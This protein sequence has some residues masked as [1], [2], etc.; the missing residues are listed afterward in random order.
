[1]AEMGVA[2]AP[3]AAL[4]P[5]LL[6]Q[7]PTL[8]EMRS[9][10]VE[11][12]AQTPQYTEFGLSQ[13]REILS[14]NP[15]AWGD[16]QLDMLHK[17]APRKLLIGRATSSERFGL[18]DRTLGLSGYYPL[19]AR[20]TAYAEL[21]SSDTHRVLAR[22][23]LH[24]Q[25]AQALSDGWGVLGG[26]RHVNYN[27]TAVDVADLTLERYFSDYRIALSAYPSRSQIAGG[28]NSYR[29]QFSRYYGAE[30]NLQFL[31]A[32]GTEV[33]KPT[34]VDSVLAASVRAVAL[35]GR[36]WL[37]RDV[38]LVYSIGRTVQGESTR[39]AASLGLRYRF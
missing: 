12:P 11:L 29:L 30:N 2:P 1:M 20:T 32:R 24:L 4:E 14:N 7:G 10:A 31:I 34:G 9:G 23:S 17:F 19:A 8:P 38:S 27:S 25:L 6:A 5:L 22:D 18:R 37:T 28:A 26:L 39:R 21:T 3:H 33:D 13:S 16:T 36:H 15:N 35:F